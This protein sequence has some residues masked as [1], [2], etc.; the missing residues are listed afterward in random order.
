MTFVVA[1]EVATAARGCSDMAHM[2][3][4]RARRLHHPNASYV[5]SAGLLYRGE[6]GL[7]RSAAVRPV[8]TATD[9]D[10]D[11]DDDNE[12]DDILLQPKP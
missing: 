2:T 1:P 8:K 11:D 9:N 4:P 6:A 10:E 3:W 12:C 7:V 5:S